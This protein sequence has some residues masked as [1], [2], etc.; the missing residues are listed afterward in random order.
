MQGSQRKNG[1]SK[2]GYQVEQSMMRRVDEA[3]LTDKFDEEIVT[4]QRDEVTEV[5]ITSI[6]ISWDHIA[7]Q[8]SQ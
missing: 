1:E 4:S 2:G 3:F 8:I 5:I 7:L 6:L